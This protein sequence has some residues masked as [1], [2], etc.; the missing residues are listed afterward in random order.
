MSIIKMFGNSKI[1]CTWFI[2]V[3]NTLLME[4]YVQCSKNSSHSDPFTQSTN[5]N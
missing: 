4:E 5:A 2:E 3:F 1:M